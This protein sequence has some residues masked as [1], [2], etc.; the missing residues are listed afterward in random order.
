MILQWN[1]SLCETL[2][3]DIWGQFL[4]YFLSHFQRFFFWFSTSEVCQ[5]RARPTRESDRPVSKPPHIPPLLNDKTSRPASSPLR[6]E[7][8][9]RRFILMVSE[10]DRG[11]AHPP[12]LLLIFLKGQSHCAS[13]SCWTWRWK[14][15]LIMDWTCCWNTNRWRRL[16]RLLQS[17][18]ILP[19]G[20]GNKSQE[21]EEEETSAG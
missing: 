4:Q 21:E 6:S 19:L 10:S 2:R 12:C 13:S 16:P 20:R 9:N 8:I 5:F 17:F 11:G 1:E 15:G 18:L 14:L 7:L 3:G